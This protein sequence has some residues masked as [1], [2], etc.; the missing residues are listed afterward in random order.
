MYPG[1]ELLDQTSL[2]SSF[3]HT[4]IKYFRK[5]F[6]EGSILFTGSLYWISIVGITI[7][8]ALT[9][10]CRIITSEEY[11]P[12]LFL[13]YIEKYQPNVLFLSPTRLAMMVNSPKITDFR[14][15]SL[16]AVIATGSVLT[17]GLREKLN[18]Y[19]PKVLIFTFYGMSESAG[20]ITS[21]MADASRPGAVGQV[22][23]GAEV[24]VIDDDGNLLD[25]GE[26]GEIVV[27]RK[28]MFSGY[29]GSVEKTQEA[30]DKDGWYR[31]GDIGYFD[32]KGFLYIV[33]RIKDI[34]LYNNFWIAPAP[35]EDK[36][37]SLDG[38]KQC[39]VVG[40]PDEVAVDLPAAV[41]V[42][43]KNSKITETDVAK[44]I[45]DNYADAKKLRG[46]VYFVDSLPMTP[47]GK[48]KR[49][50]C[51]KIATDLYKLRQSEGQTKRQMSLA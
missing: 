41:V 27:R 18:Q 10:V 26:Q 29:Y 32:N 22:A 16:K 33:D 48:M 20:L 44:I 42:R 11:S 38:V 7:T 9:G 13:R 31:T 46:G 37:E 15:S 8:A 36:I 51:K 30:I 25:I 12:E 2:T 3:L 14:V 21:G 23:S 43:A 24:K 45:E 47:S 1:V 34:I 35:L 50:E 17:D 39:A 5:L 6:E 40:V 19:L 49:K 4:F 28:I